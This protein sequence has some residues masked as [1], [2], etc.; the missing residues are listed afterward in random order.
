MRP[1][2]RRTIPPRVSPEADPALPVPRELARQ[3]PTL[4]RTGPSDIVR[5]QSVAGNSAVSG[6]LRP[7]PVVLRDPQPGAGTP[8]VADEATT[9][10]GEQLDVLKEGIA[11]VEETDP[12]EAGRLERTL[13]LVQ[14][15]HPGGL[16]DRAAVLDFVAACDADAAKEETTLAKLGKDREQ[17]LRQ[18]PQAFPN[19]WADELAR[20][21][22]IGVDDATLLAAKQQAWQRLL[23]LGGLVPGLV[24]EHGPPIPLAEVGALKTFEISPAHAKLSEPDIVR[25]YARRRWPTGRPRSRPRW[26]GGGSEFSRGSSTACGRG[27]R[28]S[29]RRSAR[30]EW[31]KLEKFARGFRDPAAP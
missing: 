4:R 19:T 26:C 17:A 12:A 25:D 27:T 13:L 31:S 16:A 18:Y 30:S 28:P 7:P 21:L 6:W 22:D 14:F 9:A 15:T 10:L 11:S 24:S 8:T 3:P 20:R 1:P 2:P 23:E 5:L 29:T